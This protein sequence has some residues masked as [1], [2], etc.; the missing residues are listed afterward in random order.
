MSDIRLNFNIDAAAIAEQFKEMKLEVEQDLNKAVANLAAITDAKVKEMASQ[1]LKTS[2]QPFMDSLGFE[3]IAPGVW[4]ISVDEDGLWIEEGIEPNKDMKPGLLA[5]NF[6]TSKDGHRYKAIPFDYGTAPSQQTPSTQMVVSYLKSQLRKEK[7]PF[8]KIE[9]NADGS[10][11][12][13]KLHEFDFG[14]PRGTMGG[15]GKG[16]TPQ[17]KNLSIYQSITKTGN[18]RRDILTFRTVS[19]GPGSQGKWHH[20]GA[21]PKHFLDRALDFAMKTWEEKILPEIFEKYK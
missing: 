11:K 1:E 7:V 4:I 3:E 17:F 14:N 18:V 5:Q 21:E 13:G 6:K 16:N 15:P 20:P 12:V 19:S 2:R 8:K 9:K 10:P